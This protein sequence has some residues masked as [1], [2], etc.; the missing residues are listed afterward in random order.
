M[1][2]AP[3]VDDNHGQIVEALL[4]Y[5]GVSVHSLA[6]VA[7]GCPDLLVGV[8]STTHLVEIKDGSKSPSRRS[9]TP[10]QVQWIEKWTGAPVVVLLTAEKARAW[11]IRELER[12]R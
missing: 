4:A 1:R 6:G 8:C 10:D 3:R 11:L 12:S 5:R 2:T 9:F 7:N